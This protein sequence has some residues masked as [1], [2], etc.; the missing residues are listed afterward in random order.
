MQPSGE[1]EEKYDI[2]RTANEYLPYF[3]QSSNQQLVRKYGN[4]I[5]S[6]R[7]VP[8]SLWALEYVLIGLWAAR[9]E[10]KTKENS[11]YSR[12]NVIG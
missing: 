8:L 6:E 9:G 10:S 7:T 2:R 11:K 5:P 12:T 1:P 4:R 3:R